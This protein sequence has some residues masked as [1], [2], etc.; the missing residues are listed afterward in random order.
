ME[1]EIGGS[2]NTGIRYGLQE[3]TGRTGGIL[4]MTGESMGEE[5]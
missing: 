4:D 2:A 3:E 1:Y 5:K